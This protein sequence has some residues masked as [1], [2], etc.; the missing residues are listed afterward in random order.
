VV[1]VMVVQPKLP[2]SSIYHPV[3]VVR[4]DFIRRHPQQ[5]QHHHELKLRTTKIFPNT[6]HRRHP[7]PLIRYPGQCYSI[8]TV[9]V[10][11]NTKP[12]PSLMALNMSCGR[13]SYFPNRRRRKEY[14][15][16]IRAKGKETRTNNLQLNS[17]VTKK[18]KLK[19]KRP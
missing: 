1:V 16:T 3:P 6:L 7:L 18:P 12:I 4:H 8:F 5:P 9:I 14:N 19:I 17:R 13:M 2:S 10:V 11:S 15:A